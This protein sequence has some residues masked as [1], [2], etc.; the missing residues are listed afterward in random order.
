[1][2][3]KDDIIKF[4]LNCLEDLANY[5]PSQYKDSPHI[6]FTAGRA[7]SLLNDRARMHLWEAKK[8]VEEDM[9]IYGKFSVHP[10]GWSAKPID[11]VEFKIWST[12]DNCFHRYSIEI[13]DTHYLQGVVEKTY[14][15]H[16]NIL[17][18]LKDILND[19]NID[20]LGKDYSSL[21]KKK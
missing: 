6:P 13:K 17:H 2:A 11:I 1:M 21:R 7:I 18:L 14:S 9:A 4:L 20:D 3:E 16:G 12:M 8:K 15:G 5:V 10:G 19:Y